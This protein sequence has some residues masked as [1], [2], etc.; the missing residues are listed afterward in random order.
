MPIFDTF[1]EAMK[2][3]QHGFLAKS[4]KNAVSLIDNNETAFY[5]RYIHGANWF[6]GGNLPPRK[7][8]INGP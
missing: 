4:T 7:Q 1:S 6:D 8:A 2:P 5:D 3:G